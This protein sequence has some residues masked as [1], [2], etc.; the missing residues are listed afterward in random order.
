MRYPNLVA[1]L[2]KPFS[3]KELVG[4]VEKGAPV[5]PRPPGV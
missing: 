5:R 4:L 3:V 1:C 2:T